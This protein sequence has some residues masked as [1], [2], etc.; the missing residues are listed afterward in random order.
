[1]FNLFY[2]PDEF[3]DDDD[4][5]EKL[6]GPELPLI[7]YTQLDYDDYYMDK[8]GNIDMTKGRKKK[9][10]SLKRRL[11]P[12]IPRRPPAGVVAKRR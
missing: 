1:M 11:L 2:I 6:S 8:Y 10:K 5:E 4:A 12:P 3:V 9:K 7:K